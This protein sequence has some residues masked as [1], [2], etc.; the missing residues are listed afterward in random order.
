MK[1]LDGLLFFRFSSF[2]C[3]SKFN[4]N[5]ELINLY[6]D[7]TFELYKLLIC[8][9]QVVNK[10]VNSRYYNVYK[11]LTRKGSNLD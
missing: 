8:L 10:F 2:P 1:Y 6:K 5:D 4:I 9:S 3:Y 7:K 11:S